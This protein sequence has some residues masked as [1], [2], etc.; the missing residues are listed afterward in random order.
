MADF[1]A[2]MAA[3]PASVGGMLAKRVKLTPD[4]EA[5]RYRINERWVSDTWLETKERVDVLAAGLLGLG[6]AHEERV[7]I[8]CTTRVEWVWFDL[9]INSAGGAV[10]TIYPNSSPAEFGHIVGHSDSKILVAENPAQAA[11]LTGEAGGQVRHI[12]LIDGEA[13]EGDDRYVTLDALLQA[14]R[15][16]LTADPGCVQRATDACSPDTLA[17]LIYTSGT[18]GVPK[19]V[20]LTHGVWVY[21]GESLDH[22]HLIEPGAV[23]YLWLPLSH[24]FGKL[25]IAAQLSIGFASAIDGRVDRIV[26]GLG[27]THPDFMCGVPRIYEKVRNAVMTSAPSG[28]IK[29]RI[30]LWAFEV[31]RESRYY[32]LEG[33]R[34]PPPLAAAYRVADRL[35]FSKLRDR[36]GGNI[37]FFISGSAKLSPQVQE[38]FYSAG[39]LIVEGYGMTEVTVP[40]VNDPAHPRFGTVGTPNPGTEVKIAE[41]GEIMLK[42]PG[43]MR[44]YHKDPELTASSFRDGWF[45]TGDIGFL[46]SDGYLTI[47]DRKKDLMKTSSGKYVAPQKVE[48]AVAANIPYVSQVVAVGDGRKYI[49][50][51]LT[52]DPAALQR[53]AKNHKR[54]GLS[55]AELTQLPE[56]RRSIERFLA[57]A[58]G[59]LEPWETIKRYAILDHEF[60]V[61]EGTTTP[62]MKVRR[63]IITERYGDIVASLYDA[64]E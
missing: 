2:R 59:K 51:L 27:D 55:Y 12:V 4:E 61:D 53:W 39:L 37:E 35:V 22:R 31:G 11:K 28:T 56:I 1:E 24:V 50:A 29:S 38:W 54:E 42:G 32:R 21:E 25:L 58:N 64:E 47:T 17:T 6:L 60:S 33:R 19:G 8:V 41:D 52:L 16:A 20:E 34:M 10:T 57:R 45:A 40:F 3:A 18:T 62:S 23:Q 15:R 36:V 49:G 46:D 30:S 26:D 63:A 44:G 48:N 14:G 9:A 43:V 13:P 7:A 5:Y